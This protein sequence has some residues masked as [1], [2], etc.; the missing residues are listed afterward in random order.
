M[1]QALKRPWIVGVDVGGTFT[2]LFVLNELT[3][4]AQIIKVP[5]TRGEEAKGFM[6]GVSQIVSTKVQEAVGETQ[7]RSQVAQ[8]A[9]IVHGTTVG[10]NALLERKVA[11]T[12]MITTRGFKDVLE[13]RRR[14]RPQTWG[15]R[16][17]FKPIIE[18]NFRRE[19]DERVLADGTLHTSVD[20]AQVVSEAKWLL[21]QGCEALCLF[22]IN[23]YANP[24]NEMQALEALK[25]V[26]PNPYVSVASTVLPEIREFERCSTASLNAALQPVVGGYLGRLSADL[27][28]HGFEGELLIVQ[29]NGGVMSSQTASEL[30]VRT[31]LSGPAAGVIACAQVAKASG[32]L[33][34]ITG[35]MGGT[36]FDVSLIANAQASLSAQTSIEFGLVVRSPMIQ[37]ETIGAGGGSIAWVD[38]SGMLQVGPQSA[39]SFPGPACYARGNTQATVTDA[40]VLLGR[41]AAKRPLGAGALQHLDVDLAQA[42]V[43]DGVA[44]PLGLDVYEAAEAILTLAN[45]KM[46]GAI[47]LV[48]IE[49]GHDPRQFAYMPF[50]GGGALHVCAMMR[51]VGVSVGIVPRYP[52]VTSALGCVMADMRH[53]AVQTLNQALKALDIESLKAKIKVLSESAQL[54]LDAS[55]VRFTQITEAV[56][57]DMLYQGQTHTLSVS[58]EPGDITLES[59]QRSFEQAYQEAFGRVLKGVAIRVLNLRYTKIG[60]RPKFDLSI[61][62]PK[63]QTSIHALGT[64]RIYHQKTWW[65]VPRYERLALPVGACVKGPAIL[66]QID[67]TVWIEPGFQGRVDEMGLLL[68]TLDPTNLKG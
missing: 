1:T 62:A 29:S 58:L 63:G 20:L 47:R 32:F 42:A 43:Q 35:D 19:V 60:L 36:S 13:M 21:E 40:N 24:I 68:I 67:T 6:H 51:E 52:G 64:Q 53:D 23:A 34:V 14:D 25:G 61:L 11:K 56:A 54:R 50:G 27:K 9:T 55:G 15:L 45:A 5:S 41:I 12:G 17:S 10:T 31:A 44:T 57:L 49:K 33:D 16:G 46:A 4:E 28:D 3:Q 37:I 66:E 26:W 30:P 39:G 7:E 59:V 18:R 38:G 2:D 8:I 22:F 48:S 65:D